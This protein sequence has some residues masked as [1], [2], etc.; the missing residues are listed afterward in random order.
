MSAPALPVLAFDG[1][2]GF[3]QAAVTAIRTSARPAITAVPWQTLPD[4]VTRPH[5]DRLDKEVLLFH[6][7][8][9]D[10]GGAAA[11]ARYVRSSPSRRYRIAAALL[12]LPGIRL[13]ARRVYALV[14]THRARMPGATAAC[15]APQPRHPQDHQPSQQKGQL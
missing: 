6:G 9:I 8:A 2:C 3:C 10:A 1:D 7:D 11:L 4:A 12:S 15:A 14:S 5:L 13:C